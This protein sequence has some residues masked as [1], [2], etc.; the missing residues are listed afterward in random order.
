MG[1]RKITLFPHVFSLENIF[2]K[3]LNLSY[4]DFFFLKDFGKKK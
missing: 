2:G 3:T 4:Q 1:V